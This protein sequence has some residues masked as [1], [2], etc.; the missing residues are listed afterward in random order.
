MISINDR[1]HISEEGNK[2]VANELS[3]ILKSLITNHH[4]PTNVFNMLMNK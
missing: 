4:M 3:I 1:V 2:I